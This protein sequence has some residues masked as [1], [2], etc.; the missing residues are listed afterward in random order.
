MD[1]EGLA[2]IDRRALD[3]G[4]TIRRGEPNRSEMIRLATA[5][6]LAHMPAGWRP[7]SEG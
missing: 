5:Y 7:D 2:R 4:L 3:E 6:G 1:A